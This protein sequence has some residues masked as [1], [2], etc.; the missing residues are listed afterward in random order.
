MEV[1]LK[2]EPH[3]TSG[4]MPEKG[5]QAPDFEALTLNDQVV[6]VDEYEGEVLLISAFPD[7]STSTCSRQTSEFNEWASKLEDIRVISISTN[8]KDEQQQWCAGK[9]IEMD[10]LRD[11]NR[12]FGKAYG[13]FIEDMDK[14]ARSVFVIDRKGQVVYQEIVKEMAEEPNYE[15][16]VAAARQASANI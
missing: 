13:I 11:V 4:K 8:T 2:G 12:S 7:I 10:M 5:V 14:L 1:T 9:G 16:A 15:E 6:H 3:Q